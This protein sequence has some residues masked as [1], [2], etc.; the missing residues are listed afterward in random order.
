M[1]PSH[2][3]GDRLIVLMAVYAV[4]WFALV[5]LPGDIVRSPIAGSDLSSYYTAGH[6]VRTGQ[7]GELYA[8]GSGDTILGDA[9]SGPWRVAGDHL[10]IKRQHYY[11]YPPFFA[12][13]AVPMS[14]MTFPQARLVWLAMDLILLGLFVRLYLN[15]RRADGI[16]MSSLELAL[17]AVTLGLEF[18][19]L[20]WALA[21]GQTSLII[22]A[23]IVAA[24][25]CA[26]TEREPA[27]GVL[28]GL[29]TA[30]KLTPALLLLY[31]LLRGRRRL[32]LWGGAVAAACT[33][34]GAIV[35]GTSTTIRFFT[36]VA[37]GLSGGTAYFLNQSLAG[38]FERLIGSGDVRQVVVATGSAAGTL[39]TVV[40]ICLIAFTYHCLRRRPGRPEGLALDLEVSAVMLLTLIVSPISWTHHYLIITIPLY[41][42]VAAAIRQPRSSPILAVLTGIAFLLIARKPHHELFAEGLSRPAL[43]AALYGAL[44]LWGI[45]LTL[46]A[47]GAG[48]RETQRRV[49]AHAA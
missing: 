48:D 3:A 17:V 30:I 10:G 47:R 6:L 22:L 18:L 28:L 36:E 38:F 35:A 9:T 45:C 43:S 42:I 7:A 44:I 11:I 23:L 25:L 12:V 37:S 4:A 16:P 15:W 46:H 40:S 34:I 31:F 27:A 13:L 24:I 20:I 14:L 21:I 26:K 41:T 2:S 32:A 1:N 49:L 8:T 5:R 39:A 29:A 33:A 19:P